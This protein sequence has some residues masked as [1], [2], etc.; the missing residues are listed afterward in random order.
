MQS[1]ARKD[2]G[3]DAKLPINGV[4]IPFMLNFWFSKKKQKQKAI[5]YGGW[6]LADIIIIIFFFFWGGGI[7][8]AFGL[9]GG[10]NITNAF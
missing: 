9:Q 8:N 5:K 4:C 10:A 6:Y 1:K 7:S 2:R 3:K